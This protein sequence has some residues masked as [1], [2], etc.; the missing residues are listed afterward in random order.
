MLASSVT[1]EDLRLSMVPLAFR[2]ARLCSV[3]QVLSGLGRSLGHISQDLLPPFE[4]ARNCV[5]RFHSVLAQDQLEEA[6]A[7]REQL[8]S[9]VEGLKDLL[10]DLDGVC[11]PA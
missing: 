3:A 4:S 11:E 10:A 7:I 1:A 5:H 6:A 8:A 2:I 9:D